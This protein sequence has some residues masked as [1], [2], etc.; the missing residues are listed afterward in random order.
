MFRKTQI[1]IIGPNLLEFF[2]FLFSLLLQKQNLFTWKMLG[3]ETILLVMA[4]TS[5]LTVFASFPVTILRNWHILIV[6]SKLRKKKQYISVSSLLICNQ[7]ILLLF[8]RERF[9]TFY[10]CVG[11]VDSVTINYRPSIGFSLCSS[12]LD[13]NSSGST[14][15]LIDEWKQHLLL[16]RNDIN[17][18]RHIYD[19][20]TF[21]D[22]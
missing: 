3:W 1:I 15:P 9:A 16:T 12:T 22:M 7:I 19:C 11:C 10:E 2:L 13:C 14:K 17:I 8:I 20:Y 18:D 4:N 21:Y 6:R 5:S